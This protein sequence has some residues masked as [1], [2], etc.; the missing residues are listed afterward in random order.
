VGAIDADG[1]IGPVA[2]AGEAQDYLDAIRLVVTARDVTTRKRSEKE[3]R[4]RAELL[5]LAHDA[6]IGAE[7]E[8]NRGA[9]FHFSLTPRAYPPESAATGE[10][11]IPTWGDTS[12]GEDDR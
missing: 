8:V 2:S 12:G 7:G 6:V 5:D 10:D 11:V 1:S 3:R 4:L 9:T